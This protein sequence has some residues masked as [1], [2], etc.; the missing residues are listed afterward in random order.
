MRRWFALG[1]LLA[2]S[3]AATGLATL[4][5]PE[6]GP[7]VRVA[8]EDGDLRVRTVS[9][10]VTVDGREVPDA[11]WIPDLS[12]EPWRGFGHT[13]R[14]DLDGEGT[15]WLADDESGVLVQVPA[16]D[17]QHPSGSSPPANASGTEPGDGGSGEDDRGPGRER[18]ERPSDPAPG[19]D[20]P[21]TRPALPESDPADGPEAGG[22]AS[23]DRER[24]VAP[25][26]AL[27]GALAIGFGPALA[28]NATRWAR[29]L[30]DLARD[31]SQDRPPSGQEATSR[32]YPWL[33]PGDERRRNP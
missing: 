28:R 6:D 9:G 5:S 22:P 10:T 15:L 24:L 20:P 18:P 26:V 23:G 4:G 32:R 12:S 33:A 13:I 19:A 16:R 25:W 8:L 29:D 7:H 11:W 21:T 1:L 2:A 30:T 17:S 3:G 31:R 27:A 14:L